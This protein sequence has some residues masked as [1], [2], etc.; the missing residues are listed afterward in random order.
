MRGK[1]VKMLR[2]VARA[3]APENREP[4]YQTLKKMWKTLSHTQKT[5]ITKGG[6]P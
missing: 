5:K 1:V 6:T 4:A 2:E 3:E